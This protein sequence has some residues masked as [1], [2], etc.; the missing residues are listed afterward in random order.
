MSSI[1]KSKKRSKKMKCLGAPSM[2][3]SDHYEALDVD[4]KVECIR[5]LIPLGLMHVQEVLERRC[6]PWPEHAMREKRQPYP[7]AA[8]GA[9]PGASS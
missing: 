8:M 2:L 9:I 5:A 4:S 1:A 7:V 3:G 6:A